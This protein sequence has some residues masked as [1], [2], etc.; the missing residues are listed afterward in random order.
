MYTMLCGRDFVAAYL[1]NILLKSENPEEHKKN[2]FEVFRMIHDY[3]SS[4]KTKNANILW[5]KSKVWDR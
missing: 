4:W 1:D 3:G 5:I 2:V